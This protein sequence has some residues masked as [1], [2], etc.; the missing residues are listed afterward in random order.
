MWPKTHIESLAVL[1]VGLGEAAWLM[2]KVV[3]RGYDWRTLL[4]DY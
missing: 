2:A 4:S 3:C 1:T